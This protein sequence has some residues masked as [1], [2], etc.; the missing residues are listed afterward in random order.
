MKAPARCVLQAALD[1]IWVSPEWDVK[2]RIFIRRSF[3]LLSPL[4]LPS[5]HRGKT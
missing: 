1:Y 4:S 5:S 3:S 2:V